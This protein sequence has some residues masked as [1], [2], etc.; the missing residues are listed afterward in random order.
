MGTIIKLRCIDQVL[1][2]D[3]TPLIASGGVEE[4]RVQVEFCPKWD[5]LVKTAV[6]WRNEEE[7]FHVL[8]D[9]E[10]GCAI[11]PEVLIDEG[12]IY[13]G[14]FGVGADGK[15][16]TSQ[17]QSYNI[18]KGAITLAS[19]PDNPTAD[20]YTQLL[21][22]YAEVLAGAQEAAQI[23]AQ[24]VDAAADAAQA[25]AAAAADAALA[26]PK[27]R[28]INGKELSEDVELSAVDVGAVPFIESTDHPGCYYCMA[29]DVKEWLNPPMQLGVE[30]R[31]TERHNEKPVYVKAVTTGALPAGGSSATSCWWK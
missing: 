22:R 15:Q 4:D 24:A 31:T 12:R 3:S 17:V 10:D 9:E 8:L 6:F 20:L 19:A 30:Y 28:K 21:A 7:A 25:A 29:G 1:T 13:L 11:P 5:G 18:V 14:F 16:R 26:V 2:F 27:T 23:A